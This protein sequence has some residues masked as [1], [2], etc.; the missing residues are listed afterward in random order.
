MNLLVKIAT[1]AHDDQSLQTAQ[2]S[3][4]TERK[5]T[6]A[7]AWTSAKCDHPVI[8]GGKSEHLAKRLQRALERRDFFV[9]DDL[10]L[11]CESEFF[12]QLQNRI[13]CLAR[14]SSVPLSR[15]LVSVGTCGD[16]AKSEPGLYI[17]EQEVNALAV[18]S[19]REFRVGQS[20]LCI[21]GFVR[22][23][24]NIAVA[25]LCSAFSASASQALSNDIVDGGIKYQ[26]D[27]RS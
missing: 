15:F 8:V 22:F 7:S 16:F 6:I 18:Q 1:G 12:A 25:L 21:L 19:S 2:F 3:Q 5:A 10:F 11:R 4:S 17:R 9:K 23:H 27:M 13:V 24:I 20:H 14:V 26:S